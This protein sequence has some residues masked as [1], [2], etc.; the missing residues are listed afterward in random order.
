MDLCVVGVGEVSAGI[1][2][3]NDRIFVSINLR[4]PTCRPHCDFCQPASLGVPTAAPLSKWRKTMRRRLQAWAWSLGSRK[5]LCSIKVMGPR[6][7]GRRLVTTT[8]SSTSTYAYQL[9]LRCA[10]RMSLPP[11][12]YCAPALDGLKCVQ[13]TTPSR[14]VMALELPKRVAA[15]PAPSKRKS[16]K[17]RRLESAQ[18]AG[19]ARPTAS[20]DSGAT[21]S[22]GTA[23]AAAR[24][25]AGQAPLGK[26]L[27]NIVQAKGEL[28]RLLSVLNA[29]SARR[30][31]T[32]STRVDASMPMV[33]V[34]NLPRQD[35][36]ESVRVRE[37]H[38]SFRHH[39]A[40]LKKAGAAL[41]AGTFRLQPPHGIPLAPVPG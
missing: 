31:M 33:E 22:D 16:A 32:D 40:T 5:G 35:K 38:Q 18:A 26:A 28:L 37:T 36:L 39:K 15:W 34:D 9:Q 23:A 19:E 3:V 41:L 2:L 24:A 6:C 4:R 8:A 17:K 27:A 12:L 11:V 20:G 7:S 10:G 21:A 25:E 29:I 13:L 1:L 30:R 14:R